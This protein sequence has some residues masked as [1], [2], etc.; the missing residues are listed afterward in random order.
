MSHEE[1]LLRERFTAVL[2][3][4]RAQR[5]EKVLLQ[6]FFYAVVA[7]LAF[8]PFREML[9]KGVSPLVIPLILCPL[10][11][12]AVVRFCP[13]GN[14]DFI[15]ALF[16]LDKSLGLE[17]RAIT[18]WEILSRDEKRLPELVVLA[19]AAERLKGVDVKVHF[20]RQLPWHAFFLPLLLLLFL[21]LV[22]FDAG[23]DSGKGSNVPQPDALAQAL[24]EFSQEV[25][26][27]ALSEGLSESLRVASAMEELAEKRKS[28]QMSEPKLRE[29]LS[30]LSRKID[31]M[32][33][34]RASSEFA[35][36]S[37]TRES[38]VDLKM[39]LET[40]QPALA[41]PGRA[42]AE[43]KLQAGLAGRLKSL[44]RLGEELKKRRLPLE[45]LTQ[46]EL[47]RLLG[48]IDQ[49]LAAELDRRSLRE[50]SEFLSLLIQGEAERGEQGDG[51]VTQGRSGRLGEPDPHQGPGTLPGD[52]PGT[53]E[54]PAQAAPLFKP[55]V[56]AHLKGILKEGS[57]ASF[58]W[59]GEPRSGKS[60]VGVEDLVVSYRRQAEE[61]LASERIPEGLKEA[62]KNYFLSLGMT[63]QKAE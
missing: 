62:V 16:H 55:G 50:I 31:H 6:S 15:R 11:A 59:Q 2:A 29:E 21:V 4:R 27:R 24:K 63:E 3:R 8:L 30:G 47:E 44:P 25:K 60:A 23:V 42:A 41:L 54:L 43:K 9:P 58:R 17:E 57:S 46:E 49:S 7:S 1:S 28:G 61:E 53:K 52:R 48:E 35:F 18:A 51:E 36:G 38:L 45:S 56:A 10:V 12:G 37:A 19:E 32:G 13:W 39:E 34:G 20:K 22:W 33:L 26:E 5:R 40:L 14:R